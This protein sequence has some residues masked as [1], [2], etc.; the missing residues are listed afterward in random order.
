MASTSKQKTPGR[1]GRR[2]ASASKSDFLLRLVTAGRLTQPIGTAFAMELVRIDASELE[3]KAL[4]VL[5]GKD[6]DAGAILR[7]LKGKSA[8]N[9]NVFAYYVR[10]LLF[11]KRFLVPWKK[12][13]KQLTSLLRRY[14]ALGQWIQRDPGLAESFKRAWRREFQ[15]IEE[16]IKAAHDEAPLSAYFSD[17][18]WTVGIEIDLSRQNFWSPVVWELVKLFERSGVKRDSAFRNIAE[19][20]S[21]LFNPPFPE[22]PNP[23]VI[24]QR[25]YKRLRHPA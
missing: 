4:E 15:G 11:K 14:R 17:A 25:F 21:A 22:K 9:I 18:G 13:Q 2:L 12:R 3:K 20:F 10:W 16:A 6:L 8:P 19:L 24:K 23:N 5:R 1:H 7:I